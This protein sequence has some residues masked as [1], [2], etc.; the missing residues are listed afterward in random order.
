MS[1]IGVEAVVRER[2]GM[3]PASLGLSALHQAVGVRMKAR[4]AA[5]HAEY[6]GLLALD[7]AEAGALGVELAVPESWFFRGGRQ[8]FARVAEVVAARAG[9]RPPGQGA[10]VLSAPCSTGEEPYSV[11]IACHES[12]VPAASYSIDAVDVSARH[13][14]RAT[15]ARYPNFSFRETG[16]DVRPANF[17]AVGEQWELLPHLRR[18]VRFRHANLTDPSFLSD[19]P[20]Y[21][22]IFCRNVFIYLTPDGRRR[23]MASLERLLAPD[24]I[25]C[26]TPGEA[27]RLP[28]GQFTASGDSGLY[29]R[30]AAAPAVPAA[31]SPP[32]FRAPLPHVEPVPVAPVAEP[33]AVVV[34]PVVTVQPKPASLE[35][36]RSLADA[37]QL[38]EARLACERMQKD[39]PA[40]AALYALLGA[41]EFAQGRA[42]AAAEAFRRSLYLDP[43]CVEALEQMIVISDRK[44]NA[45]QAA[46]LRRRLARLSR[47]DAP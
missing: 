28:P 13:L 43:N 35:A 47:E 10:R 33:P 46:A 27:D 11:A 3:D 44:G 30:A 16:P 2:L 37:G 29:R 5:S 8:L 25:L 38:A 40:S 24:G 6:A 42:D 36:A 41:I 7:P 18:Q 17:R 14:E 15:A 9:A 22:V 23:A 26:L 20:A 4:G 32:G 39:A 34:G 12:F 21:D 19:E 45:A 31:V 1:L